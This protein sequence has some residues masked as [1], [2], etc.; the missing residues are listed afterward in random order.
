MGSIHTKLIEDTT[1]SNKVILMTHYNYN[2]YTP[3]NYCGEYKTFVSRLREI[4]PETILF[5]YRPA[6]V[7]GPYWWILEQ[8]HYRNIKINGEIRTMENKDYNY[9]ALPRGITCYAGVVGENST[10]LKGDTQQIYLPTIIS[11][12]LTPF[13]NKFKSRFKSRKSE[14]KYINSINT[15]LKIQTD[16]KQGYNTSL[17]EYTTN[18]MVDNLEKELNRIYSLT[19]KSY[20]NLNLQNLVLSI[21]ILREKLLIASKTLTGNQKAEIMVMIL[22]LF[23]FQELVVDNISRNTKWGNNFEDILEIC[24]VRE[25]PKSGNMFNDCHEDFKKVF[26]HCEVP[27]NIQ[28]TEHLIHK[29]HDGYIVKVNIY[30]GYGNNNHVI[31]FYD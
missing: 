16:F 3:P 11:E 15:V 4:T 18:V 13:S 19:G 14:L 27:A 7:V 6:K 26:T 17:K 9:L 1:Y 25:D 12:S 23:K 5:L 8:H 22:E 24:K 30:Q 31:E 28:N 21:D 29:R 10:E 20:N 2:D